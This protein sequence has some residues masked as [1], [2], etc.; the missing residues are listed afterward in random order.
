MKISNSVSNVSFC[1]IVVQFCPFC[2][3]QSRV[4]RL[5]LSNLFVLNASHFAGQR[6]QI[7]FH[8]LE[9]FQFKLQEVKMENPEKKPVCVIVGVGPNA[10][11]ANATKFAQDGYAL[12]LLSR[13]TNFTQE[14]SEKLGSAQAYVCDVSDPEKIKE[15]FGKIRVDLGPV[16][17]LV[18]SAS[19]M[20]LGNIEE[21]SIGDMEKAWK[22]NCLGCMVCCKQV[23]PDMVAKGS[24]NIII[25]GATGSLRGGAN[26]T[27][28]S[29]TKNAQRTLGES[30][31]RHLGPKGVH[32]S[33]VIIDGAIANDEEAGDKWMKAEKLAETLV[34][35]TKQDKSAWTFQLDIRPFGEKW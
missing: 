4:Y 33:L 5:K 34:F 19:S 2:Q 26:F 32:V 27:A 17:V 21:C 31:A 15:V 22:I 10:G 13:S 20:K 25:L 29:S 9:Q 14:L 16:E 8:A 1:R 30:M 23:I 12:A 35:L 7:P 18:Y 3:N 6:V 24:G 11:A 28:F